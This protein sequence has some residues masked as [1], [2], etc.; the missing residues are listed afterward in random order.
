MRLFQRIVAWLTALEPARRIRLLAAVAIAVVTA[1]GLSVWA[2]RETYAPVLSGQGYDAALTAAAAVDKAGIPYKLVV[3]DVLEVPETKLGAAR[4]AIASEA[5]MPG[6][7]DVGE[8]QLGLTPQAQQW[9]FLRAAEA[10]LARTVGGIDGIVAAQV[11]IV[12]RE[13]SLYVGE[14]RPASASVFLKLE[15]GARIEQSQI[16]A[17]VKLVA[18]AV[19]GLDSSRVSVADDRGN[20]L[21]AGDGE[22]STGPMGEMRSLADYRTQLETRYERAVSQSLLPVV[23]Y[24]GGYSVTA[25]VD[26]DLESR[27]TTTRQMETGKQAVVSEVNEESQQQQAAKGGVPGVDANLPERAPAAATNGQG[28]ASNRTTSTLNYA[29]P[30]VDEVANRP[31][32]GVRRVSVAVQ[33]DEARIAELVKASNGQLQPDALKQQI[34]LA[35][36][37]AVGYDPARND[38]VTVSYLPFAATDWQTSE[39]PGP[40]AATFALSVLPY[41]VGLAALGLVFWFVVRPIVGAAVAPISPVDETPS[42]PEP[43]TPRTAGDESNADLANRLKALVDNFQPIDHDQLNQL[44]VRESESAADVLRKWTRA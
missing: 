42:E 44:I 17:V 12:P 19:D 28:T 31:A 43:T 22:D 3:P 41:L 37:A 9:A 25:T 14:Q 15:P 29:Y 21:A 27:Q 35:I 5:Q 2:S 34:D 23:G 4:S 7:G 10:N 1:V 40:G 20:L 13:E 8:L 32:G 26:L 33:V 16:R 39:D 24:G 38:L 36:R 6:L 18:N 30:T 11:H